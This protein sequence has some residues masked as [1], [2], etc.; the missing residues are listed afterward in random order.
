M[1]HLQQDKLVLVFA[2]CLGFLVQDICVGQ[3]TPQKPS[4]GATSESTS[5]LPVKKS[6]GQ[7]V[8]TGD[9]LEIDQINKLITYTGN[10][11]VVQ[12]EAS[13]FSDTLVIHLDQQTGRKIDKAV[14]TGNVRLVNAEITATG[15]EGIFYNEEQKIELIRSAK[16]W[17]DN[18]TIT[19][20]RIIAFLREEIVEGY[21]D[22]TGERAIMTVY[23]EGNVAAF[24]QS[25]EAEQTPT[26]EN[27][28]EEES[29]PIVIVADTLKLDNLK[30]F[31][32]FTGNVTA[33]QQITELNSDEMK[34]YIARFQE[35]ENDVE[36]I[37][38]VGNVRIIQETTT[39][40]GEKGMYHN[41]EQYARVEG[42]S[43]KK[44]RVEDKTQNLIL[45]AP[46]IEIFLATNTIRAQREEEGEER[47]KMIFEQE[48]DF[49]ENLQEPTP[50]PVP[51]EKS[52]VN[53]ENFPSATL[54]PEKK[55]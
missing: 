26:A 50:T 34:V 51:D 40:T 6:G 23:S 43:R 33:T 10:V 25:P 45:E 2:I 30:G 28:A 48:A 1:S 3:E 5:S 35:G 12:G 14:A 52:E 21:S 36:K 16:V 19:A 15:D 53:R 4:Q 32:T 18:N 22:K 49:I 37:E 9:N 47:V 24:G 11:K 31:A 7:I 38:V 39:V 8:I 13:L 54:F 55:K 44:A 29:S 20:H 46:V 42:S 17:Q 27:T 41:Q